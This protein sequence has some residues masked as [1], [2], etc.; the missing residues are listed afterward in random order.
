MFK[1][2]RFAVKKL[3][4]VILADLLAAAMRAA[5]GRVYYGHRH[6]KIGFGFYFR[7][8]EQGTVRFFHIAIKQGDTGAQCPRHGGCQAG[9]SGAALAAC[10]R[11]FHLVLAQLLLSAVPFVAMVFAGFNAAR[12]F[13]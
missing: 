4:S 2:E 8:K 9:F 11:E 1:E 3:Y 10:D 13:V 12:Q 5:F 6:A 7:L